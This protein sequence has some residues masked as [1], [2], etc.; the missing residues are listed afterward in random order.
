MSTNHRSD[1]FHTEENDG[2]TSVPPRRRGW[3]LAALMMTMALAAMDNTIV[4]TAI[5]QIVGDLGGFSLFNWI[6]SIY[7]LLQTVTIP[8][9]GK[10]ADMYGRK[11]VLN[12]GIIIF[13][14][15]SAACAFSWNMY[16]LIVFRGVQALGAGA[17]IATVNTLAGDIYDVQ[18][19]AKIQGW[20]SSVWGISAI[21]GPALGGAFAEYVTWHW[22]FLINL[23][24]G[25]ISL[26]L[27]YFFLHENQVPVRHKIQYKGA[28]LILGSTGLLMFG[29]LQGG[30]AWDWLSAKSIILFVLSV[31]LIII[32]FRIEAKSEEPVMPVWIWKNRVLLGANL[33]MIGMGATMMAP[34]MYLPVYAQSVTGVG[35]IAAGFILASTS[36]TWPLSSALSGRLYLRIGF[37]NTALVGIIIVILGAGLFSFLPFPGPAWMLVATQLLLGAGFG[38]ISTPMIVGVQSV[39]GWNRRGVVTGANMFSRYFG[40]TLGTAIFAAIFNAVLIRSLH[41]APSGLLGQL[42][43][44][45]QVIE[46]LQSKDTA[47]G[48][49]AFLKQ[50]FHAATHEV[51]TGLLITAVITLIIILF[52][53][54]RFT[55]TEADPAEEIK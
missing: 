24:I 21:A 52:T 41:Q 34:S 50:T 22:I 55:V 48:V 53:P 39:V 11:P 33:T 29:L 20:L 13:L 4:S 27:L 2:E 10:L 12:I 25:I 42:P 16:S 19:R 18:E 9:Y 46:T 43:A 35:A 23:P 17:I 40:Q 37:R 26:L 28:L 6:F 5:P 8:L 49:Q 47:A 15:G 45:N 31:V 36:L 3:I 1:G 54:S 51:Y 38:F 32:A 44:A 7:L 14:T 30:E